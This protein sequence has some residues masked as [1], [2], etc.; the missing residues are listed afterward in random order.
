[1][2]HVVFI[3]LSVA[4]I[5]FAFHFAK[6]LPNLP[7][8]EEFLPKANYAKAIAVGHNVTAAGLF[9]IS[10]IID[11][12]DSYLSG[13]S[14]SWLSHVGNLSTELDS[15]FYTPYSVV[16]SVTN[17][18]AEDTTDFTVMRRAI[19]VYPDDWRLAI[20]F[21]LRL[22][23]GPTHNYAEA[24]EVM[25]RFSTNPDTTIPPHIKTIYRNFELNAMQTEMAVEVLVNDAMNP[26]NK[27]LLGSLYPKT[28][29][30]LH[31]T[32]KDSVEVN[33]IK[34]ILEKLTEHAIDPGYAYRKLL[35][36]KKEG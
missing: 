25:R 16:G 13:Q 17:T 26:Q 4:I 11:L 10:G 23:N 24:A 15:L 1:M 20:Y 7:Q 5:A 21:A 6:P 34:S 9:W 8:K 12:G 29:R 3:L 22:A 27:G 30:V 19:R 36:L 2:R 33:E 18:D 31:R 35:S 28:M 14:Y 32:W